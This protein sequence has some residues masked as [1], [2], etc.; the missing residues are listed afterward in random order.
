MKCDN[1]SRAKA[2]TKTIVRLTTNIGR[3]VVQRL[4]RVVATVV[5]AMTVGMVARTGMAMDGAQVRNIALV[6]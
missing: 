3:V 2:T 4:G 5:P 1:H 6:M